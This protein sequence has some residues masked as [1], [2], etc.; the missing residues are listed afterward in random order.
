MTAARVALSSGLQRVQ[1]RAAEAKIEPVDPLRT[2]GLRSLRVPRAAPS[3]R[4]GTGPV[5]QVSEACRGRE[6]PLVSPPP[7][8]SS[9]G[10]A[11]L[12]E[13]QFQVAIFAVA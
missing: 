13:H 8:Q 10:T 4:G 3:L 6:S 11:R 1:L 7:P 5:R 12:T 9:P 2:V